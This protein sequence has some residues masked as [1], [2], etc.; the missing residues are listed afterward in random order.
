MN[1]ARTIILMCLRPA[2]VGENPI[3]HVTRDVT[4]VARDLPRDGRLVAEDQG[5]Q[6]LR[7]EQS[8]ESGRAD[9]IGKH[10]GE[11]SPLGLAGRGRRGVISWYFGIGWVVVLI[12][13]LNRSQE[14]LAMS[15]R[16][17][18]LLEIFLRQIR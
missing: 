10:D 11:L 3:A 13:E 4:P 15:H 17:T 9:Q 6:V 7:V 14:F 16:N 1:R 18:E 2:E 12:E 5:S 8:R